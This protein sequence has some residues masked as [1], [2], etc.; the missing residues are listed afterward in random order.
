MNS[1]VTVLYDS[2]GRVWGVYNSKP[3]L[4]SALDTIREVQ[5]LYP[6]PPA[7]ARVEF[8]TKEVY[9][10][11]NT[12]IEPGES[13]GAAASKKNKAV[14]REYG[15]IDEK[16][17]KFQSVRQSIEKLEREK[18]PVPEFMQQ[19]NDIF[20]SMQEK[21]IPEDEQFGYWLDASGR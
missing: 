14:M 20:K 9:M 2:T 3:F 21:S 5:S 8:R 19:D 17:E 12:A 1:S 6:A 11:T 10:N 18:A 15:K 16:F 13:D 4:K 7:A